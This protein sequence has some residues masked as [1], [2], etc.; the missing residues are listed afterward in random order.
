[1]RPISIGRRNWPQI[2]RKEAAPKIAAIFS[3][4]GSCRKLGVPIRQ[5]MADLLPGPADRSIQAL[6][7]LTPTAH[8]AKLAK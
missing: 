7:E 3:I 6:A 8:A 1:M 4:I 2:G 5:Y